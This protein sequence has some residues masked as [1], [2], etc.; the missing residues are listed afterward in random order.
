MNARLSYMLNAL[1]V[2]VN[3]A[4]AASGHALG[5]TYGCIVANSLVCLYYLVKD[6][7]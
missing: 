7:P 6:C 1:A 3:V 2:A 5:L 4:I